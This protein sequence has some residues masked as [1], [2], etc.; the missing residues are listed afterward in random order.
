MEAIRQFHKVTNGTITIALPVDFPADEVE[1]IVLPKQTM[2]NGHHNDQGVM[3]QILQRFESIDTSTFT[4]E[5]LQAFN[6][7]HMLLRKGRKA[8][9]PRMFG[10][11]QGLGEIADDFNEF[12]EEYIDLFY[13]DN[14]FS[15]TVEQVAPVV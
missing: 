7:T 11:F 14:I 9:E 2:V 6:R 4:P 1:V 10:L 8:D 15:K 12:P 13:A 5:Q 3:Q